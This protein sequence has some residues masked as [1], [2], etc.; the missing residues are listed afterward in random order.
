MG[1]GLWA[2][3]RCVLCA[4]VRPTPSGKS[5]ISV[6]KS[7]RPAIFADLGLSYSADVAVAYH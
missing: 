4:A 5:R 1:C 2:V 6:V 3:G 7:R